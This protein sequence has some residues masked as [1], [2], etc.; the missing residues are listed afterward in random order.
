MYISVHNMIM[1]IIVCL[2][3]LCDC[4]DPIIGIALHT[5]ANG[6]DL[7]KRLGKYQIYVSLK[8]KTYYK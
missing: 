4:I 3:K 2:N 8:Y 6:Y 1:I 5:C 7:Q